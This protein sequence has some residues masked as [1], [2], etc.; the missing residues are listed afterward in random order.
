VIRAQRFTW[1]DDGR[2]HFGTL[3]PNGIPIAR[4]SGDKGHEPTPLPTLIEAVRIERGA[5][6]A[7]GEPIV[8]G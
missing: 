7:S 6:E 4:P 8:A 5:S 3:V 2:P 1:T